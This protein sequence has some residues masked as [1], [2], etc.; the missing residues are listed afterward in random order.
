MYSLLQV[1]IVQAQ[2]NTI[3]AIQFSGNK[4]T[5]DRVLLQELT[6]KV[7]DP[8]EQ[9]KLLASRQSIMDL[10][11]FLSVTVDVNESGV[12][13]FTVKE[14]HYVLL[15]PRFSHDSDTNKINPGA[16]LT[17]N[18]VGGLNQRLKLTYSRSDPEDADQGNQD[19]LGVEF[20]YPKIQGSKYNLNTSFNI[21]KAPLQSLQSG[22]VVAEYDKRDLEFRFLVSRWWRKTAPSSGWLTGVGM[23]LEKHDYQYISGINDLFIDDHALGVI[24]EIAYMDVRDYLYSR[25]GVQYGYSIEHGL[26]FLGSDYPYTRHLLYY[27]RYMPLSRPHHNLNIQARLGFSDGDSNNLGEDVFEINGYGDLRA[28]KDQVSGDAFALL[29][30]E[31]LRPLMGRNQMRG[32]LFV[33]AGN[34]YASNSDVDLSDLK[35]ATGL[36]LRWLIKGYVDLDLSLE[37]AFNL[38]D[39]EDRFYFRTKGA[40]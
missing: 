33:D 4:V 37:Y 2:L 12:V 15:L 11:L 28:Y 17:I 6:I 29:N 35:W 26:K 36:G 38:E 30:I 39:N 34:A 9:E 25:S 14:K 22:A 40:F 16:R 8:V 10:G 1:P 18:N 7:G 24:G 13:V 21:V 27:R 19:E 31:Y 3:S 20:Y 5:K 23:H 32:L